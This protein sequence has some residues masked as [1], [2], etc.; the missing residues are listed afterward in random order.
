MAACLA[1]I[2]GTMPVQRSRPNQTS[3]ENKTRV[4]L[5]SHAI[6]FPIDREGH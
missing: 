2:T 4:Y 5:P 6:F 3:F 1:S